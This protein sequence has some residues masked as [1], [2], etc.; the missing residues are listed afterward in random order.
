LLRIVSISIVPCI[1]LYVL[2]LAP[3][4]GKREEVALAAERGENL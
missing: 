1:V 3:R 2:G 4:V